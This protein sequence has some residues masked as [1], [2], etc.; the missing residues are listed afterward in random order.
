MYDKTLIRNVMV[1]FGNKPNKRHDVLIYGD[2]ITRIE[3]PNTINPKMCN[4]IDGTHL[5]LFPGI[6]SSQV[7]FREPGLTH[8]GNIYSESRAAVAGGV[9]SYMEMPNVKPATT[10]YELLEEKFAIAKNTSIANYSF[11]MGVTNDN[12]DEVMRFDAKNVC[13]AKIF[14]GSSTGNMLVNNISSI[15][16]I[17]ANRQ[18][19]IIS[20]HCEDDPM[21][22]IRQAK[23]ITEIGESNLGAKHHAIIRNAEACYE[24]SSTMVTLAK[25]YNAR[26][27]VLH[28]ST[29]KEVSLFRNDIPLKQK[30]ITAEACVHHLHFSDLDYAVLG[31]LIVCNPAIKTIEDRQAVWNAVLN[32][33]IDVIDFDHA[34]HTWE[35]KSKPYLEAPSGIPLIQHGF[36]VMLEKNY[37]REIS[38][39]AIVQKMCNNQADLFQIDR[40]GY[41]EEGNFADLVLVNLN[42]E[43]TVEKANIEYKCAWSPFEGNKFHSVITDTFV[44]GHRA[45]SNGKLNECKLGERLIFNR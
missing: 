38:L 8:K 32:G 10:T 12:Y 44:N 35:E 1:V 14:A 16:K 40:R 24:S 4:I 21:I 13:G 22:K 29:A 19:C 20:M 9:T 45:Y 3:N 11:F 37:Q 5:Y 43:Y 31:N 6:I 30:R 27:H 41:I 17:M 34:P 26:L 28:I 23:L 7:H 25:S 18:D 15:E 42:D 36:N 2:F 33:F 39:Q